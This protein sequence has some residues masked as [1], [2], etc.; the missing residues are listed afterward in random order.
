L[1]ATVVCVVFRNV[2]AVSVAMHKP[3]VSLVDS[4][5]LQYWQSACNLCII[6]VLQ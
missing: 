3:A 5:E 4:T 2:H 1:H 6:F